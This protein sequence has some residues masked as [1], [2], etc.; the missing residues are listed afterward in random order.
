MQAAKGKTEIV[1]NLP[2]N[3]SLGGRIYLLY[4]VL[5][6]MVKLFLGIPVVLIAWLLDA[7][8]RT[9]TTLRWLNKLYEKYSRLDG[10]NN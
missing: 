3:N 4:G 5:A 2:G 9:P 1:K 8:F 7:I 10:Y 6:K